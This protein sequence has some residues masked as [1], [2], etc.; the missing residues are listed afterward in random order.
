MKIKLVSTF[1]DDRDLCIQFL[2]NENQKFILWWSTEKVLK[3]FK[4][5]EKPENANTLKKLQNDLLHFDSLDPSTHFTEFGVL[6]NSW[7][8]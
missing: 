2:V 6:E 5:I 8:K 1:E 4:N 3:F 7:I